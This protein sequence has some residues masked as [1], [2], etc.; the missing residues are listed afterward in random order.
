MAYFYFDFN[1]VEKQQH[2]KM[3]RSLITHL[4]IQSKST[5]RAL[6]SLFSSC[7][8]GKRQPT[9]GAL[10]ETLR[11]MVQAFDETFIILDALDECKERRELLEDIEIFAEWKTERLHILAT[12][13]REKDIEERIKPLIHDEGRI[14]IQ[15]T[16]VNDDIRAYIRER[17]QT[18][19]GLR[20][21]QK[22]PEV[23]QEIEK[24]LVNKAG[25]M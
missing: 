6:E 7:M 12:S 10:L 25:G 8:D 20:R 17:L 16:L 22:R 2:E 15:S 24:T 11:Q 3:I 9:T 21:W 13:R 5:P 14:C 18:D 23:Q 19:W 1:D 4:S